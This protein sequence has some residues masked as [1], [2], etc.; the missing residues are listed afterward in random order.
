MHPAG[1]RLA[2]AYAPELTVREARQ[3]R[4]SLGRVLHC[5]RN[6]S[7]I[8]GGTL[9]WQIAKHCFRECPKIPTAPASLK[10]ETNDL[11][12]IVVPSADN[13]LMKV[14]SAEGGDILILILTHSHSFSPQ[15]PE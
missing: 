10:I 4:G 2:P 15:N 11:D 14:S 8:V 5:L 6:A 3:V 9:S 13:V 1:R 7:G 12:G